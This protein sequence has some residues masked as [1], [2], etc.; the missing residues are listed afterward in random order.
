MPSG[1][2]EIEPVTQ[3]CREVFQ[4]CRIQSHGERKSG[5]IVASGFTAVCVLNGPLFQNHGEVNQ[6]CGNPDF[7]EETQVIPGMPHRLDKPQAAADCDESPRMQCEIHNPAV[8]PVPGIRV[9]TV[10]VPADGHWEVSL[11]CNDSGARMCPS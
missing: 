2:L 11:Q 4:I 1:H 10:A 7:G 9:V 5:T 8:M 3:C 6:E